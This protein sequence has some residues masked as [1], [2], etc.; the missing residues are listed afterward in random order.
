MT[1]MTRLLTLTL[2]MLI[3]MTSLQMAQARGIMA[4]AVGQ[5]VLCSG[6]DSETITLDINGNPIE[7]AHTCVDCALTFAETSTRATFVDPQLI[8]M[9]TLVQ[10]PVTA[11][12]TLTLPK[13]HPAR[14]PPLTA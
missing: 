4:S 10:A 14:A 6:Q 1:G 11:A 8:H 9:Q 2:A 3:A 12:F 7:V 13:G 5:Y